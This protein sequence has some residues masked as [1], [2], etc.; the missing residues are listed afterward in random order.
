MV[1]YQGGWKPQVENQEDKGQC[2]FRRL[3]SSQARE[4]RPS[5]RLREGLDG[6]VLQSPEKKGSFQIIF[7]DIVETR[8]QDSGAFD[9]KPGRHWCLK[10]AVRLESEGDVTSRG[11]CYGETA[12]VCVGGAVVSIPADEDGGSD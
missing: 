1:E 3:G 10:G 11:R 6:A 4:R 8:R 12:S 2:S 9:L 7:P 5:L